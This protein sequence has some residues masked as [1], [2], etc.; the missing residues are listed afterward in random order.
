MRGLLPF[1]GSAYRL[2]RPYFVSEDKWR[3]WG[4][5]GAIIAMRL[6]LVGMTVVLSYWNREFFNALQEKD[7]DAFIHL[8]VSYRFTDS[9]LMPGF[10]GIAVVYIVIA[11]Y[12]TYLVQWLQI[13]WRTW[14][15]GHFLDQWLADRAYYRIS[16]TT[17]RAAVGTDN[18]D[19]RI[20]E[21]LRDFVDN[22][23]SLGVGLLA[24]VVSI[25][26]F[27]GI[28]WGLSGTLTLFGIN[29]PGY[30]VWVALIYA[31]I[32]TWLTH[33]VGRKLVGLNFRRQRV[34]ADF[35]YS[36]V[37][38]RE[39]IE[40]VAL[41]GG[42]D[43]E[44]SGLRTRFTEIIHNWWGIM[45]RTKLLNMLTSGYDQVAGIFPIVVAAPRYFAGEIQLGGL[46]QTA[47]AFGRVQESLS[48]FIEAYDSL[49]AWR[50]TVERL[51]TF[52]DAIV[53]ARAAAGEGLRVTAA[54]DAALHLSDVTLS[55][56]GGA[57]LLENAD[58]TLEPGRSVVVTGRSGSGKSTLFRAI[59][60]I[61]PFG[62][63]H[64]QRPAGTCMFLPQRP[65]IPLGT[66]AQIVC[67]P[68]SPEDYTPAQIDQA[69][70]DVG[71]SRLIP[72]LA[73]DQN[74]PQQ[75]SGGE[76]QRLAL[77][78]ALLA[79]PDWLFLDEATASMDPEGEADLYRTLHARLPG[80]TIV[81]IA[82][83]P[84][85]AAVHD[86]QLTFQRN[87]D[88]GAPGKLTEPAPVA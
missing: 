27:V 80:T 65:Y 15:T 30:M 77:A 7:W 13:R 34:E 24:N 40:G 23:L 58:L 29:I 71:L 83:R 6:S 4:L 50:A 32:G 85:V 2:A 56:P 21:D 11:V 10:I 87:I 88:A 45:R 57:N 33:L 37:R 81:S 66:L 36:L 22:T 47:G 60:G 42:E 78:R 73:E 18:P 49:A 9:G 51:T 14:L 84:A 8:L 52:H 41:Y 28:L 64:V 54:T 82:H 35:R 67:Y 59:A 74:W 44:K 25:F 31:V 63:G 86:R 75:L 12:R 46:T 1:L 39:N 62:S 72:R 48:W 19:Q 55:L 53:Q 79:K 5:L 16:L 38:L 26:S 69:L 61:W 20:A 68:A 3:A 43:E 70:T 17:D 76:Q